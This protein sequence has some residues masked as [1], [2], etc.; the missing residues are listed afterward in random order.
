[1]LYLLIMTYGYLAINEVAL[2]SAKRWDTS[3]SDL[4]AGLAWTNDGPLGIE[5]GPVGLLF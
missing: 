3:R 2:G 5:N 1:M 4:S